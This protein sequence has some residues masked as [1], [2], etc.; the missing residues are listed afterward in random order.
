MIYKYWVQ[1]GAL[2][3]IV[4]FIVILKIKYDLRT[5]LE[6]KVFLR[7]ESCKQ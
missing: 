1:K 4:L 7:Q 2:S 5:V 3:H 6:I